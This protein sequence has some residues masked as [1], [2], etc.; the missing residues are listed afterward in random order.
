M[1]YQIRVQG[2]LDESWSEWLEGMAIA[3]EGG[4]HGSGVTTI[5]GAIID[6]AA[7]HGVLNRIR[8][9][10]IPLISVQLISPL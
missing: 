10:N 9:L 5:T 2:K 6:Q 7:L 8:D 4:N 1:I 3:F